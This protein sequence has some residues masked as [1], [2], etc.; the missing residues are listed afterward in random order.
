MLLETDLVRENTLSTINSRSCLYKQSLKNEELFNE[1][2][3]LKEDKQ[4]MILEID[5]LRLVIDE[6]DEQKNHYRYIDFII[7][8]FCLSI[9]EKQNSDTNSVFF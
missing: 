2:K 4:Q 7:F 1:N 6:I 5:E 3:R 9:P 8:F